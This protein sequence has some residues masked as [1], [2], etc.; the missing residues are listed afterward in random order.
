MMF[1]FVA[2]LTDD[3]CVP[4][5]RCGVAPSFSCDRRAIDFGEREGGGGA[6]APDLA[7]ETLT[8]RNHSD[9][10]PLSVEINRIA[11]FSCSPSKFTLPPMGVKEVVVTFAPRQVCMIWGCVW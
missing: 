10:L 2:T 1:L 7:H 6:T 5:V 8:V 3:G 9:S 4:T 11:H